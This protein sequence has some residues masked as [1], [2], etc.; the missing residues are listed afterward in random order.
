M[1]CEKCGTELGN[2]AKFCHHCGTGRLS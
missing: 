2:D 1:F